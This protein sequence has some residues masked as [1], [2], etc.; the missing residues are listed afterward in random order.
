MYIYLFIKSDLPL[1]NL[2]RDALESYYFVVEPRTA[3]M[4][5]FSLPKSPEHV[6]LAVQF[7]TPVMTC[8][9]TEYHFVFPAGPSFVLSSPSQVSILEEI[10]FFVLN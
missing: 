4:T 1:R 6:G 10:F 7:S 9:S 3:D 8:T 2:K 5:S